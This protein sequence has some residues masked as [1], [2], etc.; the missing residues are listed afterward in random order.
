MTK[1][2]IKPKTQNPIRWALEFGACLGIDHWDLDFK[3]SGS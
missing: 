1:C 3:R 2:P